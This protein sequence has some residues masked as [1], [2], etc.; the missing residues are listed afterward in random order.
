M[1]ARSKL[2]KNETTPLTMRPVLVTLYICLALS[3]DT[4]VALRSEWFIDW[5][6][7]NYSWR[8]MDLTKWILW[9]VVPLVLT[10]RSMNSRYFTFRSWQ[11]IDWAIL[12]VIVV[13]GGALMFLL[14]RIPGVGDYYVGWGSQPLAWR[15]E[16]AL[17]L[18]LW[19]FS[20]LTG[21][22]FMFRYWLVSSFSRRWPDRGIYAILIVAP[23]LEGLY[24]VFQQKPVLECLGMV[25]F[26]LAL[27]SWAI[28]RK[29]ALL[30]FL[31]HLIIELELIG[32]L[33]F[34][35]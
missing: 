34:S 32:F 27:C 35:G 24:H 22:E 18:T 13:G 10:F 33:F 1:G 30:P 6:Q 12:V 8:G 26:S 5:A 14:P 15:Q 23:L 21:W 20:W 29:N 11:R 3:I 19:T 9:F 28:R 25:V 7:F 2:I 16:E 4:L 17:R 31:G